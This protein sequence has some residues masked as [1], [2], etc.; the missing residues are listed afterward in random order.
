MDSQGRSPS[1]RSWS[2]SGLCPAPPQAA[3]PRPLLCPAGVSVGSSRHNL[4]AVA[5]K[6]TEHIKKRNYRAS[7]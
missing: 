7:S 1:S 6:E 3:G 2:V 5:N 4:L